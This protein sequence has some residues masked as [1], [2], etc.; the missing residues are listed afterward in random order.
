MK[1]VKEE[2]GPE[3]VILS[4][5]DVM[6]EDGQGPL[7]EITAGVGYQNGPPPPA[8]N[9]YLKRRG[10]PAE[11]GKTRA[12]PAPEPDP[13]TKTTGPDVKEIECGLAEIKELILDLTHRSSLN[14]RLRDRKDLLKLYRSL[15]ESEVDP[16]IA[17][18]LV[19][20]AAAGN[21]S[22]DPKA[23]IKHYLSGILKTKKPLEGN[24]APKPK[25]VS[26]IGASG[27][28]KTTTL[29]KLA[30]LWSMRKQKKLALISLDSFRL[31]AAEQL[32]TYARI[33][34]LP[35]RV[36]QDRDEFGQ[37]VE[38]FDH[39]DLILIDTAG[40]SFTHDAS[41]MEL[42]EIFK[43]VGQVTTM[44]VLSAGA[45]DRDLAAAIKRSEVLAADGLIVSKIDETTSYGNI[46]NNLIKYKKPVS[47]L[48][49]GQKVPD[50]IVPATPDRLADLIFARGQGEENDYVP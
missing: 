17:R 4:T 40:R 20:K 6:D 28:G 36:V 18:S 37:A 2:M 3:A 8:R 33:M 45:K 26:V 41:R 21:G 15:I 9:P 43:Q 7:V 39:M 35:V 50:D 48:T 25:L 38:L 30:A 29:A 19:E 47:F 27:V 24:F 11:A 22:R 31:G 32:K 5:R 16:A 14:E 49:N 13:P 12:L 44:L 46:I 1:M 10:A 42:A 23:L 34:G